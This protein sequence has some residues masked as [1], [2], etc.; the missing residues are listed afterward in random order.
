MLSAPDGLRCWISDSLVPLGITKCTFC[1]RFSSLT[2]CLGCL[3]WVSDVFE[4]ISTHIVENLL[5]KDAAKEYNK[6]KQ[7]KTEK[8]ENRFL[9]FWTFSLIWFFCKYLT[10]DHVSH[11]IIIII[12]ITVVV[13]V[14]VPTGSETTT[15]AILEI[16]C[17]PIKLVKATWKK[18]QKSIENILLY[19]HGNV[20][21]IAIY[22][23]M[24]TTVSFYRNEMGESKTTRR[25][26]N[27][28]NFVHLL[29]QVLW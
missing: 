4:Q 2:L 16:S 27:I 1:C 22:D 11:I 3:N 28:L 21:I 15:S 29:I 14:Q 23:K 24:T 26:Q 5:M 19:R 17:S 25:L 13:Q 9:F 10:N 18:P 6:I 8:H 7:Q 20:L 12:I